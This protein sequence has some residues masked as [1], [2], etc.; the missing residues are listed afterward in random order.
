MLDSS[1]QPCEDWAG[2]SE[3]FC[4]DSVTPLIHGVTVNKLPDQEDT[5][6]GIPTSVYKY[7]DRRNILIYVGITN[8]GILRNRQHNDSKT[9]W[10]FVHRQEVEHFKSRGLAHEREVALIEK[11]QPPFNK[12][13]N[14][15]HNAARKLYLDLAD[16]YV[17]PPS[18]SITIKED[19]ALPMR[20]LSVDVA[21]REVEFEVPYDGVCARL[22]MVGGKQVAP[23]YDQN[24]DYLGHVTR[25]KKGGL[26]LSIFVKYRRD[27]FLSHRVD[28]AVM[29]LKRVEQRNEFLIK[30]IVAVMTPPLRKSAA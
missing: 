5:R 20:Q 3:A 22:Q 11:F 15:N 10:R 18:L 7:Y 14:K 17:A 13:H 30:R 21:T 28:S 4:R 1:V 12:Q 6:V 19:L 23:A 25:I 8:G 26:F 29:Y 9:W 27:S 2:V 16:G 24:D